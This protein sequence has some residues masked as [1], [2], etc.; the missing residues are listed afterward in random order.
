MGAR[1]SWLR[2]QQLRPASKWAVWR[3]NW[4]ANAAIL[5]ALERVA[6]HAR[7]ALLDIGCGRRP[8]ESAFRGRLTRYWG[9]DLPG[10]RDIVGRA[11]DAFAVG[12]ALP[13]RSGSMDT[14]I[15]LSLLNYLAEPALTLAEAQRV[16]KPGGV[17]IFEFPQSMPLDPHSPDYYRFT[18]FAAA[19]LLEQAGFEVVERLP[20]GGLWRRVGMSVIRGL[21]RLNRGPTRVLTE[22]PVRALYVVL[23]SWYA[24]LDRLFFEDSE[25]LSHLVVARKRSPAGEGPRF[26]R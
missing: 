5:S 13:I 6:P 26:G 19:R 24:L 23:Q 17:A 4:I 16:L 1:V 18:K 10:S 15:G 21:N 11:P 22:L 20:I 3:Y 12:E 25:A 7:G 14:V 9:V 8:F 2:R